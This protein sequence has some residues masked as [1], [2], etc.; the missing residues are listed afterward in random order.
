MD[1]AQVWK[2]LYLIYNNFR[3][4]EEKGEISF[5]EDG[6]PDTLVNVKMEQGMLWLS[7]DRLAHLFGKSVKTISQHIKNIYYEGELK[8]EETSR[9]LTIPR[10]VG[11]RKITRE[12]TLCSLELILSISYRIKSKHSIMFRQ[13]ATRTLKKHLTNNLKH[14]EDRIEDGESKNETENQHLAGIPKNDIKDT[15][16]EGQTDDLL[17]ILSDY[18]LSLDIL[19]KYD[20]RSISLEATSQTQRFQITHESAA[21]VVRFLRDK[22]P[23][24]KLFGNEKDNSFR[25]SIAAIYQTFDGAD[26]YPSIEE[27]AANLLYFVIKNHSFSDGN[28][29]IARVFIHLVPKPEWHS[30][31]FKRVTK[32][33][34]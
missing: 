1:I 24:N 33:S 7:Q 29:R 11:K 13:W 21:T 30:L 2:L 18:A 16:S 14:K 32:I 3:M 17:N 15:L 9:T 23:E 20:H 34:K 28:K 4:K 6:N 12:T 25:S 10:L 26:L 27:K 5:H 22:L 31:S 8:A 19:N